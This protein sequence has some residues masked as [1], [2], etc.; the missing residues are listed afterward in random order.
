MQFYEVECLSCL[1][2]TDFIN[3]VIFGERK[4][5]CHAVIQELKDSKKAGVGMVSRYDV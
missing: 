5:L 4:S 2:L 1:T 3:L